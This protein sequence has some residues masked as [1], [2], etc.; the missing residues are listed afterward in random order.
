M[1]YKRSTSLPLKNTKITKNQYEY[2]THNTPIT[3]RSKPP[4]HVTYSGTAK[5]KVSR[6]CTWVPGDGR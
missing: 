5:V 2:P 1:L 3:Y 4:S 6:T